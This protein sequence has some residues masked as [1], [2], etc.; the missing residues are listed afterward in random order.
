M[1]RFFALAC[2]LF[3]Y[4]CSSAQIMVKG[5]VTDTLNNVPLTF[6]S[7]VLMR[8]SDSVI[9]A[10]TRTNGEGKFITNL[11]TNGKYI[12]RI[13][14]PN[15]ADYIDVINIKEPSNDLG[16]L[17]LVSKEHLL[18]EFVI[19][20][21]IAAI[22]IKGDTTEYVADSFK[23]KENATVE[24][25]LKKLPGIQVDKDGKITAQGAEVQKI[26][27]DGEEFFS[28][29]PKVVT[30]GLLA[31]AVNTV[32]VFDKKSDQAEFTGIDDG[33]KTK[34]INLQ[35]KE[36]KKKGYFGKVDAGGGTDGYFQNQTMVNAFKAKRQLSVFG[37]MSN[38]DQ[39]GLGWA[40]NGK[41]NGGNGTTE[42]TEDGGI[43]TTYTSSDQDFAGWDGKYNGEGLPKTWTGGLHYADKWNEDKDHFVTNY[44][45][46]MQDVELNGTTT[47]QYVLPGNS[48]FTQ[49]LS[50]TQFSK[51]D[52]H[53]LDM[54]Y[55][56]KIDSNTTLK[57]SM[58]AGSK[59][60]QTASTYNTISTAENDA[61]IN[62]NYR[63]ITSNSNSEY[64]NTDLLLRKKFAKKG[65]TISLDVKEKY[66][67]AKSNGFLKSTTTYPDTLKTDSLITNQRKDNNTNDFSFTSKIVYT[68]PLS[69]KVFLEGSYS[70]TEDNALARISSF[71]APN[72]TDYNT[73]DSVYSSNYKYNVLT[74]RGGVNI[75][76]KFK[77]IS[78]AFGG[79]VA[80]SRFTQQN[81]LR[82]TAAVKKDY[83]NIYPSASMNYKIGKQT[84]LNIY[85][86][87]NTKQP[88][89]DQVNP[90]SQNTDPLNITKGNPNLKQEFDNNLT[91][92]FND[93]K[94]LSSRY[95]YASANF[96]AVSD[97]ISTSQTTSPTG[98]TTQFV[99]VNGN[100]S[101]S[102][103]MGG[104]FKPKSDFYIGMQ[105]N[106]S[107]SHNHNFVNDTSNI[108]NNNS[109]GFGPYFNYSKD[110]KFDFN[111]N[112]EITFN[113]NKSTISTFSNS[114]RMFNTELSASV[115]LPKKFEIGSLVN[116][117]FR[118][119][120]TAFPTNNNVIK[121]NAH[122]SRKFLKKDQLEVRVT[123]KDILNQNIGYNRTSQNGIVTENSYNTIRRYG[124]INL[125]WNFTHSPAGAPPADGGGVMI[126]NK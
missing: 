60:M 66:K 65:R 78:L 88:T 32:Q 57:I 34:T 113:D 126:I 52:R 53:G 56:K 100:Y 119:K 112:P 89:I 67:D 93:Y 116:F 117:M 1:R 44:R 110:N 43:M 13:T 124:M 25:L 69:K 38:T 50:K 120:T 72:G 122:V 104:G 39:A 85:Y 59:T 91:L 102:A 68:E 45:Y 103:Y 27:V 2:L 76:F 33:Q 26:L 75:K 101:G 109:Y 84:S 41:F 30:K 14:Y 105:I 49:S 74:N 58:D 29:D 7:V 15:F 123:V 42:V 92:Q 87:G 37:I 70:F 21:Q 80:D 118:Q 3:M 86:S 55:E 36:D 97:A 96:R 20:R 16:I 12:L 9:T 10:F 24:D 108:S 64:V 48:G 28:D 71:N 63:N 8:A 4:N 121:W 125:I 11:K 106:T 95:I 79:D 23:T 94:V 31:N 115:Q 99:N 77:K 6:S 18:K 35:L 83:L 46:A 51:G 90:L 47:T 54:M 40:D 82:D 98:N 17:P 62:T 73:L 114:Y 5:T 107:L 19:T 61:P 81:L 22:K 111:L